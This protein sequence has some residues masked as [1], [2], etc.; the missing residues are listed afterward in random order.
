MIKKRINFKSPSYNGHCLVGA[1]GDKKQ[2]KSDLTSCNASSSSTIL[3]PHRISV[4][5]PTLYLNYPYSEPGF[6]IHLSFGNTAAQPFENATMADT[7][8]PDN[9]HLPKEKKR[10]RVQLSCTACRARKL[11][12]CRTHPCNN[13]I[14][15]G[16]AHTCTF[17]GRGPRGRSSHGRASPTLVQD[18][19]QHLENLV[20]SFAQ[21]KK[22]EDSHD[23]ETSPQ[24]SAPALT[25]ASASA[26][27][28][29]P[30]PAPTF[31]FPSREQPLLLTPASPPKP[32]GTDEGEGGLVGGTGR[33]L[34]K[35]AV[36]NY[37]D[38]AHWKAILEEVG[39]PSVLFSTCVDINRSMSF[40]IRCMKMTKYPMKKLTG[41]ARMITP[42][43]KKGSPQSGS[44]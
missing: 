32:E 44:E 11:K 17:V 20:L 39:S 38:S 18:R 21:Q 4:L 3:K 37:I 12:C 13:C 23:Q 29:A 26:P 34:V 1:N 7:L 42:A 35:D 25:P 5:Y 9:T 31:E 41:R 15:R 30:A 33:L 22:Q 8:P 16:E 36:T 24:A 27:A 6:R 40:K 28:P 14:K 10:T 2:G 19:L 43:A